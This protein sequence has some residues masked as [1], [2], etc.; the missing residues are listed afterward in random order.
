MTP[1]RG[2]PTSGVTSAAG[3]GG[4]QLPGQGT[5]RRGSARPWGAEPLAWREPSS[6]RSLIPA[7]A[8]PSPG[9]PEDGTCCPRPTASQRPPAPW[10]R[11]SSGS[12][13][14]GQLPAEACGLVVL[15]RWAS[16][17]Q[18]HLTLDSPLRA[19]IAQLRFPPC[20][21]SVG[22][23]FL[24]TEVRY[25]HNLPRDGHPGGP[26][27]RS[28]PPPGAPALPLLAQPPSPT[29][30]P[31]TLTCPRKVLQLESP[32]RVPPDRAHAEGLPTG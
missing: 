22:L 15:R 8:C 21:R 16:R 29:A 17:C 19:Q 5:G 18:T 13:P 31:P 20:L 11:V 23:G 25:L 24:T 3:G 10:L 9:R 4:A 2:R 32:E 12:R 27:Q 28:Q 30:L 26:V 14:A 6:T 1:G 7:S